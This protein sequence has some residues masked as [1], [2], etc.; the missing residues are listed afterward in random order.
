MN[1]V[2]RAIL[3]PQHTFIGSKIDYG[4]SLVSI[5]SILK[6]WHDVNMR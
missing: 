5:R 3:N 4:V 6:A 2:S 1:M